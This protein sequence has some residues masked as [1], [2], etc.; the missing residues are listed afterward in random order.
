MSEP[1]EVKFD[2]DTEGKNCV[3]M[4]Y[5]AHNEKF[6]DMNTPL[7]EYQYNGSKKIFKNPK[8]GV[9][10]MNAAAFKNGTP[11][12][13]GDVVAWWIGHCKHDVIFG[14]TCA[15]CLM[16]MVGYVLNWILYLLNYSSLLRTGF[17]EAKE[18]GDAQY[19]S[20]VHNVTSL[21]VQLDV[22]SFCILIV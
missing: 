21:L 7:L 12:A 16:S 15:A 9:L 10:R 14:D 3:F 5:R 1:D 18:R 17:M 13:K 6:C 22:S 20:K 8:K 11:L 19:V 4:K 2:V